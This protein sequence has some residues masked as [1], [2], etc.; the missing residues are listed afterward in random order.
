MYNNNVQVFVLSV[1]FLHNVLLVFTPQGSLC[2]GPV[3]LKVIHSR[4]PDSTHCPHSALHYLTTSTISEVEAVTQ[5][6]A[7]YVFVWNTLYVSHGWWHCQHGSRKQWWPCCHPLLFS[8]WGLPLRS[9]D[10]TG[11]R[12]TGNSCLH[13]QVP[14]AQSHSVSKQKLTESQ[15]KRG[16]G[17]R[18]EWCDCGL[19]MPSA[20]VVTGQCWHRQNRWNRGHPGWR[21][22]SLKANA[23]MQTKPERG[24]PVHFWKQRLFSKAFNPHFTEDSICVMH[25]PCSSPKLSIKVWGTKARRKEQLCSSAKVPVLFFFFLSCS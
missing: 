20:D 14:E 13:P 3:P 6:Y 12:Q 23:N 1:V 22:R 24:R 25:F 18:A 8:T 11:A 2:S 9:F 10:S 7:L 4:S 5:L 17:L 21:Y 19:P 15:F 16:P